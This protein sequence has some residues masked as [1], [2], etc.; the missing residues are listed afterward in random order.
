MTSNWKSSSQSPEYWVSKCETT[1]PL[2]LGDLKN[3]FWRIMC[4]YLCVDICKGFYSLS[5]LIWRHINVFHHIAIEPSLNSWNKSCLWCVS[6]VTGFHAIK[7]YL[8][9]CI[10]KYVWDLVHIFILC[11]CLIIKSFIFCRKNLKVALC[12]FLRIVLHF[13]KCLHQSEQTC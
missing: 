6:F 9:I 7:F 8:P 12:W 4:F 1:R 2:N 3:C 5:T 11:M 10:D 13:Y